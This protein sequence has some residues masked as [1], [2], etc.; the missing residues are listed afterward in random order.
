MLGA[1]RKGA[2]TMA[3]SI[4]TTTLMSS[5]LSADGIDPAP[6]GSKLSRLGETSFSKK[7]LSAY[8]LGTMLRFTGS[9]LR[10]YEISYFS[11]ERCS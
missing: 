2:S 7:I 6:G 1:E 11:L 4:G 9:I 8:A 3:L 5:G 10:G